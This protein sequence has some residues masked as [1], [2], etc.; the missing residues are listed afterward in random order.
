[1][2]LS[3]VIF[4]SIFYLSSFTEI[5]I[6][7]KFIIYSHNMI[8]LSE[9][10][11]KLLLDRN[12]GVIATVKEDGFPHVTPVWVDTDGKYVLINTTENR[13]KIKIIRKNPKVGLTVIDNS[14]PYNRV[15]I[16]GEVEEITFEGAEE[17]IDKLAKKYLNVDR[18]PWRRP[19]DKRVI[20][21][22]KPLRE[23]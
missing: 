22:I 19:G 17:H 11:I 5:V 1:M 4:S 8:T 6:F 2:R 9:R 18:Y 12:F 7:I 16:E 20:I 3:S 15:C 14:D 23:Y 21:K 10:A 13:K